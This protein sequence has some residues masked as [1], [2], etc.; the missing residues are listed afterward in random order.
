M[1]ELKPST[2]AAQALGW[3]DPTFR[4]VVPPL[5]ASTVYERADDGKDCTTEALSDL[6]SLGQVHS[7]RPRLVRDVL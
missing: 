7:S 3:T 5:V 2:L 6:G 1:A 4:A